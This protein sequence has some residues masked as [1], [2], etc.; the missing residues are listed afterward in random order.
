[1]DLSIKLFKKFKQIVKL[2]YPIFEQLKPNSI[3][4]S[5]LQAILNIVPCTM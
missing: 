1:M 3:K 4:I 2:Q 5:E